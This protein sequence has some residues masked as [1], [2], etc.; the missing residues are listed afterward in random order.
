M[1]R[2]LSLVACVVLI[3]GVGCP[4]V[5]DPGVSLTVYNND[6]A[7][8]KE[9]REMAIPQPR[10]TLRFTDVA[11]RI[12]PA[13]VHFRS[14]TDPAGTRVLEQNYAFDLVSADKLLDKYV[15]RELAVMTEDGSRYEGTLLSYDGRQLVL[16]G[17]DQLYMVQR[18]DNVTNIEFGKLPEGLLTRPTL[19]WRVQTAKPGDHDLQIT[20][21]TS[22][23]SWEADYNAVLSD[24]E[25]T[26]D[27]GGW[28]TLNNQ[29]GATYREASVKLIAGDV[30]KV[31][32]EPKR[33]GPQVMAAEVRADAAGFQEKSFFEYHLYT[34]GRKTTVADNQ[35]KQ[36]ELLSAGAVP[37]TKRYVFEPHG[38]HWQRRYGDEDLYKVNVFIEFTND[39]ASNLGMA[40]PKG[41][42]RL[43]KRDGDDT[44]FIGEDLIA[45][46]PRDEQLKLYV[47]DAFDL[48]GEYKVAD[49][50]SG[51]RW[52]QQRIEIELRNHKDQDV[53][54][55]VRQHL[56]RPNGQIREASHEF[57]KVDAQ[58]V[59]FAVPVKARE[60]S[61][62]TFT[63]YFT[64]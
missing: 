58:T 46:T 42:V 21:Q 10:H 33:A 1:P 60:Q 35:M 2:R 59:E 25:S 62:L 51:P 29:S 4:A 37:V 20:Y 26:L 41:K 54:I 7:V 19:V 16:Q 11:R 44:E 12:D 50:R 32:D 47:G 38:R 61:K 9:V 5:A 27:L 63:A 40:L 57:E 36:I 53:E 43:Y 64:W 39:E 8:V 48:V 30:R 45:H 49:Q 22:G 13:S 34:L 56:H 55:L 52:M 6:F 15:D 23:M 24:D 28:V 18:P 14:L 31:R 3:V 17:S